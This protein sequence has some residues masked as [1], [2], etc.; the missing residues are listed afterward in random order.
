M[1]REF[2]WWL[3]DHPLIAIGALAGVAAGI[4]LHLG[5][6]DNATN[7]KR[8]SVSTTV[9]HSE[10][11]IGGEPPAGAPVVEVC[12]EPEL[13]SPVVGV[14]P[15]AL[16]CEAVSALI[17]SYAGGIDPAGPIDAFECVDTKILRIVCTSPRDQATAELILGPGGPGLDDCG[18][19]P[20]GVEGE[21]TPV[22]AN[23]S[24]EEAA[25][26]ARRAEADGV[27]SYRCQSRKIESIGTVICRDG[28][29]EIAYVS[30]GE[31]PE[32]EIPPP[33]VDAASG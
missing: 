2:V 25:Q 23:V 3:E 13:L 22:R 27:G 12:S 33:P 4:V 15:T 10:L 24:C 1:L 9:G 7:E 26:V 11:P 30:P 6:R 21:L 29:S 20:I 14:V 31:L 19:V 16:P 18:S 28:P 8:A 32:P 17:E 5:V